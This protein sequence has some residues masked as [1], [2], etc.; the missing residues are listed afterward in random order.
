MITVTENRD[1]GGIEIRFPSKPATSVLVSLK[2]N[3]WR[4]SR[5]NSCWYKRASAEARAFA[6]S[7]SGGASHVEA[8]SQ[9]DYPCSDRG[10]EDRCYDAIRFSDG[11]ADHGG[12]R[13]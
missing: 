6:A 13:S 10:Y 2:A 5:F 3:G 1:K 4:W 7:L 12:R 11:F 8:P 9:E